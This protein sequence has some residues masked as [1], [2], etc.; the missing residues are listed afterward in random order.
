MAETVTS[1]RGLAVAERPQCL[2]AVRAV[3]ATCSMAMDEAGM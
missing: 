3:A 2:L 1:L